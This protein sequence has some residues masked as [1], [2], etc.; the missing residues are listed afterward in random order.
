MSHFQTTKKYIRR[1]PYQALSAILIM[2][3]TF[4]VATLLAIL[5]YSS[6]ETL[7]YFETRPQVIAYLKK[8][9]AAESIAQLQRELQNDNRVRDLKYV[10]RESALEIYRDATSDKPLLSQLV[11]PKIFPASL[12]F[13][14]KDLSETETVINEVKANAVVE[15]VAYTA[16]LGGTK[17]VGDVIKKLQEVTT[18]IRVGGLVVLSFL[19]VSSLIILLVILGMRISS[20]RDEIEILQLIGATSGFIRAPFVLEGIFYSVMGAFLGWVIVLLLTLYALPA[21]S[22]YF[23]PIEV[24]PKDALQLFKVEGA[25]LGAELLLAILLGMIGSFIAIKRYLKI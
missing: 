24:L 14:V 22:N 2:T 3:I 20:R 5:A 16:S 25:I 7:K 9:A 13:S 21:V 12:E 17:S 15:Q 23:R 11:S 10:S 1:A 18:Y 8:D 19:V 6:N 4:F